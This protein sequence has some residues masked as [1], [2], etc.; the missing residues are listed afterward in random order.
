[1]FN[2][3]AVC[4]IVV[5]PARLA[6]QESAT[7][8]HTHMEML[9]TSGA[10]CAPL[11]SGSPNTVLRTLIDY[12]RSFCE[13][14]GVSKE[15]LSSMLSMQK[16]IIPVPNE[17][18]GSYEAALR[19]INPHIVGIIRYGICTNDCILFQNMYSSLL[20]CPVC[21]AAR[22]TGRATRMFFYLP[23]KPRLQWLFGDSCMAEALQS[24]LRVEKN[25]MED[26]RNSDAWSEAYSSSGI[27]GGDARGIS[28]ALCTDGVNR[29]AHNKVVYSMWP[30]ML[31]LLNLPRRLRNLFT[32]IV[33]W[34][35]SREQWKRSKN[36]R[37]IFGSSSR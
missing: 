37:S 27:F 13:H 31:T 26:I 8:Q 22:Q 19:I 23:L 34:N 33:S 18:P 4:Y 21:G 9:Y 6:A 14:P 32:N 30:I 10:A 35:H 29:F 28:L 1:M 16:K 5:Y 3:H 11:Y 7:L 25:E 24:H 17:L 2:C 15:A 20:E 12:F 36:T